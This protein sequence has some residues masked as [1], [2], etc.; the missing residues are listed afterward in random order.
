MYLERFRARHSNFDDARTW[1]Y[2][3]GMKE[4]AKY[5]TLQ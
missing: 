2:E 5:T 4:G 3:L 1:L